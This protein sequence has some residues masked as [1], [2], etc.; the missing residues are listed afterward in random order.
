LRKLAIVFIAIC[1][2]VALPF[3]LWGDR[4][5]SFLGGP[6]AQVSMETWGLFA[7]AIA[8]LLLVADLVLPIPAT[9]VMGALGS[10]YGPWLGGLIG[11]LGSTGAGMVG[12]LLCRYLGRIIVGKLVTAEEMS[13]A[14]RFIDQNGGLAVAMSR[15]LPVL[16]EAVSCLAGIS[17]MRFGLFVTSLSLGSFTM[18]FTFAAIGTSASDPLT[19]AILCALIPLALWIPL[20][21]LFAERA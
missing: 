21:S 16:P 8:M 6:A 20:R 14:K 4:F 5:E 18:A 15:W 12:Y 7:W 17:R 1:V 13:R 19:S 10:F 9:S 2:L 11:G 3:V